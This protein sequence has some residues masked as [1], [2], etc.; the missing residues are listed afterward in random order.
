MSKPKNTRVL[1]QCSCGEQFELEEGRSGA[2]SSCGYV[3]SR[4]VIEHDL[5]M[6]M[7][8]GNL[9]TGPSGGGSLYLHDTQL[10]TDPE[11]AAKLDAAMIGKELGHFKI[12]DPLGKGGQ[13]QVFRALDTSL[14][15][16]VAVKVLRSGLTNKELASGSTDQIDLLL[17]EAVSQAR[18]THPNIV[19]IYYV[20]KHEEAPFLAMELV[21]GKTVSD[22]VSEGTMPYPDLHSIAMQMTSALKFSYELDI[23]HGDIKPSNILVQK[24]GIAKLS[25]FG[26]ARRASKSETRSVGG[27]PNYLAPELMKGK[28]PSIQ[29]D[30]YALGVTLFEMT[31]GRLPVEVSG[32]TVENWLDCHKQSP[33][34]FPNP[35]PEHLAE[36]WRDVLLKLLAKEPEDRF[37]S[38]SEVEKTLEQI[39]P[40]APVPAK[41]APRL[42]AAAIDFALVSLLIAPFRFLRGIPDFETMLVESTPIAIVLVLVEFGAIVAYTILVLLWKQSPGRKLMQVRVVNDHG[43]TVTG[44]KMGT[45]SLMRMVL[46]WFIILANVSTADTESWAN[47]A[48]NF[49]VT[50]ALVFTLVDIGMM[51]YNRHG[52]SLHDLISNTW[53][54]ID[55]D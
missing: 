17:Q 42:V 20:G 1:F 23:I 44:Q 2:C 6:T 33:I 14:R 24:N 41:R 22:L 30:M 19:T 12:V 28:A 45:R 13:G 9:P 35:W 51:I 8:L 37:A 18:V 40:A 29:S 43:L 15:R 31:F 11:E 39:E 38:W 26:M 25:D 10:A 32:R 53:V 46:M 7:T 36:G 50:S 34:V 47:F 54:V 52:R 27:T 55:T 16:Y 48:A 4:K 21:N 5:A 49:A 3:V